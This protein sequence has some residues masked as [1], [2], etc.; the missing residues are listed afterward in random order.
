MAKISSRRRLTD[1]AL[2]LIAR[3][4]KALSE[5]TR[6]KL[7]IALEEG[8][9]NVSDSCGQLVLRRRTSHVISSA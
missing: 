5:V 3:R 6:L 4:F 2:A 7:V 8:E 1:E 9:K